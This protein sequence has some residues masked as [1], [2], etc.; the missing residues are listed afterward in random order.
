MDEPTTSPRASPN[1]LLTK[2]FLTELTQPAP[3]EADIIAAEIQRRHGK[4]VDGVLFYGSC[5]RTQ[6]MTDAVLDFYVLVRSYR[7]AYEKPILRWLNA[8]LPPNVFYLE[9]AHGPQTLR[10]KYAVIS[11]K[12]FEQATT[13]HTVPASIWARFCQPARLVYARDGVIQERVAQATGQAALTFIRRAVIFFASPDGNLPI[14]SADLW[15]TGFQETYRTEF[16]TER[17][18]T[19]RAL[20]NASPERYD[21]IT[22]FGLQRLEQQRVFDLQEQGGQWTLSM[23]L[24]QRWRRRRGWTVRRSLAKVL[25]ALRLLKTALTFG[26]WLPYVLWKL[27]RHTGVWVELSERQ[28]RYPLIWGWPVLF[29]LLRLRALR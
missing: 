25:Y 16:R 4:A 13:P 17:P 14:P 15:H 11:T 26:D 27:G 6:Q 24:F 1:M 3:Q 20:Y 21:Q 7:A 18:E 2:L 29:K 19:I 9:I 28:R 8:F 5:Q 23:P 12:D 22:R 10:A